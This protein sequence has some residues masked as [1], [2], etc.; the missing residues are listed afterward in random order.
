MLDTVQDRAPIQ[1][2]AMLE[3]MKQEAP[4]YWGVTIKRYMNGNAHL[5]FDKITLRAI[6]QALAEF[7]GEVL[8]DSPEAA[9]E[10]KKRTGTALSTDLAY[11]PTPAAVIEIMIYDCGLK[12]DCRVLE[13]SCGDGRIMEAVIAKEYSA[14]VTGVE[15][16][17]GR[18]AEAQAK[19]LHV[20]CENFLNVA[21][22]RVFDVV[23]MNPPFSGKHYQKHIEHAKRFL[24]PGG[25]LTAILPG[26][27]HYDHGFVGG[28]PADRQGWV[29]D[30]GWCDLPV[31]SFK[32]SG[33]NIPTGIYTYQEP[34]D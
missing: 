15:V 5:I 27:A 26:A 8:A 30:R 11:Y 32:E 1:H 12:K 10:H 18:A 4:E 13:P 25:T 22:S 9:S 31:G 34:R 19:G 21:P 14:R 7:Y 17:H 20:M 24:V 16:H 2:P 28:D 29:R 3:L 33:T 23:L 6:N